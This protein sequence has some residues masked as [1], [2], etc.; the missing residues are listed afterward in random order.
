MARSNLE[1]L[2]PAQAGISFSQDSSQSHQ[3]PAYAG[4][5]EI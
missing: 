2:V 4:K 5:I 1:P 3:I